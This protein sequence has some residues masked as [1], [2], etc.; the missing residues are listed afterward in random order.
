[1][2]NISSDRVKA[3]LERVLTSSGFKGGK[4]LGQFLSYVVEQAL[5]GRPDIIKQYTVAVDAFGY[6]ADFDPQTNPIVRIEAQRLRR[7]L[8]QY[9][10]SQGLGDPIRIDVPKGGYVPTFVENHHAPQNP[11]SSEIPVPDQSPT[12][13]D[14]S[15]PSIA[16]MMIACLNPE[17]AFGYVATGLTEEIIIA[18]TRFP[19]FLV[20][21]P[22]TRDAVHGQ[23]VDIRR[24]GQQ[25]GVRFIMDGTLR[26]QGEMHRLTVRLADA[27]SGQQLWGE[28][29]EFKLQN[30]SMPAVESDVVSQVAATIADNYGIIPRTLSMESS[31]RKTESPDAYEAM[32]RFYH[33]C[34]VLTPESYVDAVE[35]LE[36]TLRHHPEHALASAALGDLVASSYWF[37]YDDDASN[38]AGAETLAR[39]AVALDPKCQP[40]RYTMA[41]IHF[42]KFQRSL[43]LDEA[44]QALRLNPNNVNTLAVVALHLGMVG[45]WERAVKLMEKA[46][47]LNPHHPGW[48]HIVAFMNHYRQGEYDR[49]W[50]EAKR[51][52]TPEFFWDPLIRAATLGQL[53]RPRQARKAVDDLLTLVPDFDR[54][55]PSLTRRMVYLAEHVE[56]LLEGL[57]KAGLEI[58]TKVINA[59]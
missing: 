25:Y 51:F 19:D 52:N 21:G 55:G 45:D 48:Y 23:A 42:L 33:Y 18:L 38:L 49:A 47:R 5:N 36:Q 16:V 13:L 12:S 9:Y 24:I 4:R 17:D 43:F 15:K 53:D 7:A 10:F 11:D 44:E 22:L 2:A 3:Q 14:I 20:V 1:M 34:R 32:L 54:R 8:D 35:A 26:L 59:N 41:L 56:M 30:G 40:A 37:G 6:G 58:Q 57:L 46:M 29:L 31:A 28:A 27:A 50:I 39:R